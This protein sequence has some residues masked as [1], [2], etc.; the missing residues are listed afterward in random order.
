M[1]FT[2]VVMLMQALSFVSYSS[3]VSEVQTVT[4]L[5]STQHGDYEV[6]YGFRLNA[7]DS[8]FYADQNYFL[9]SMFLVRYT[10]NE[11]A[12]VSDFFSLQCVW[13]DG[14]HLGSYQPRF[15]YGYSG[16]TSNIYYTIT[17]TTSGFQ[18]GYNQVSDYFVSELVNESDSRSLYPT[19]PYINERPNFSTGYYTV[20]LTFYVADPVAYETQLNSYGDGYTTGLSDG[21][22]NGK[23]TGYDE[24]YQVGKGVGYQEGIN[25]VQNNYGFLK[26]FGTIADTPIMMLR[27]MFSFDLFGT[28]MLAVVLTL[29]TG[30]LILKIVKHIIK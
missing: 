16:G 6:N 9:N 21:Y 27:R 22:Q 15:D 8:S 2:N 13:S 28:S 3:T 11:T 20:S 19:G 4:P 1:L 30:L 10:D 25:A 5:G 14:G 18:Q 17:I 29:F 26:L 24:G 7:S 12:T 23:L